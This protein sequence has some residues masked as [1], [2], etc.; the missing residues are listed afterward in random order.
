MSVWDKE[1]LFKDVDFSEIDEKVKY[2]DKNREVCEETIRELNRRIDIDYV[3]AS[4][5]IENN[6]MN[7]IHD[8]NADD[9]WKIEYAN[10]EH[11][12]KLVLD[13]NRI[14]S[15]S[16]TSGLKENEQ[17]LLFVKKLPNNKY[18][19]YVYGVPKHLS[20]LNLA[21]KCA[22]H[23]KRT[24]QNGKYLPLKKEFIEQ[25]HEEMFSSYIFI[26]TRLSKIPGEPPIKPAGYGKFRETIYINGKPHKYNCEVE[27]ANWKPADSDDV[28]KEMDQL[29]E[30]Y[31]KSNLHPILK[32]ILFKADFIRI[33]PFRDGNGRMSRI[34]LNYMLVRYGIPTITIKGSQKQQYFDAMNLAIE[35][36]D[37]SALIDLVKQRLNSRCNKYI[38]IINEY[39]ENK[40]DKNRLEEEENML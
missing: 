34:L 25:L 33:H 27:G 12:Q 8:I 31:N 3:K 7:E 10:S 4:E 5:I 39:I 37:Y 23:D 19:T 29:I 13:D 28:C 14:I 20:T 22:R 30:N 26:N 32:A 21:L 16:R 17:S 18:A 15:F 24:W 2:I 35:K 1:Q 38:S 36:E 9:D 40:N 11:M 6:I